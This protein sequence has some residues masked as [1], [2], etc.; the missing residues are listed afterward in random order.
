[1]REMDVTANN[2]AN[3]NTTG[4]KK[5][6]VIFEDYMTE[7]Q[8]GETVDFV[9]DSGSYRDFSAGPILRTGNELDVALEGDGYLPVQTPNGTMYTRA[10]AFQLNAEGE[11]VT[12]S[13]YQVMSADGSPIVIP[14]EATDIQIDKEGTIRTNQGE[15]GRLQAMT[16]KQEQKMEEYGNGLYRTN[17]PGTPS[18]TTRIVQGSLEKSNVE[19]VVE[20]TRIIEVLRSYQSVGKVLDAE[21]ERQ[22]NA[23]RI[24]GKTTI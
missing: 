11:I 10:G 8:P 5:S 24:L 4:F 7:T 18:E 20:M 14:P 2:I 3:I 13:G 23:I 1:M 6:G 21:N 15:A 17:E 12:A 19:P 22:R 16:F 9:I